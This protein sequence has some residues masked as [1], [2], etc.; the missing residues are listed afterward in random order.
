MIVKTLS[1][2]LKE[3]LQNKE[4]ASLFE[5]KVVREMILADGKVSSEE[6]L[7]L[8]G[9]LHR[10]KFDDKAVALLSQLIL[11]ADFQNMEEIVENKH[12]GHCC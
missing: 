7:L 9:A 3:C 8:E 2:V 5:A 4:K 12:K 6:R 10:D 11:R 1:E